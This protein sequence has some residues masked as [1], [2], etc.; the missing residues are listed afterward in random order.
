[1]PSLGFATEGVWFD[2]PGLAYALNDISYLDRKTYS[3]DM[4]ADLEDIFNR[5]PGLKDFT[6]RKIL[7]YKEKGCEYK[8]LETTEN[9]KKNVQYTM[10]CSKT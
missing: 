6:K 2:E 8:T 9:Q 7:E 1:M 4:A 5:N 10:T 3:G